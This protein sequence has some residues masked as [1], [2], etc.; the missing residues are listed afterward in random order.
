MTVIVYPLI[1][2]IL[3]YQEY[4]YTWQS[5]ELISRHIDYFLCKTDLEGSAAY[6]KIVKTSINVLFG[7]SDDSTWL[8]ALSNKNDALLF[9]MWMT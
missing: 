6:L 4:N 3:P 8:F 5:S 9:K 2:D 1:G 7:Y